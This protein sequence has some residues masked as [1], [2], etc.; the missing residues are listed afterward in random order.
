[1][2]TARVAAAKVT[3]TSGSKLAAVT[4]RETA[5]TR[6]AARVM[7]PRREAST[8]WLESGEDE[9]A[10][11]L[12]GSEHDEQSGEPGE[13]GDRDGHHDRP[14]D[15]G[16]REDG[17]AGVSILDELDRCRIVEGDCDGEGDEEQ[18]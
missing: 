2:A 1:M 4:A 6:M 7:T 9:T 17:D 10:V 3:Q 14:V 16:H 18:G 15:I 13:E 8:A 5:L 11:A 12:G